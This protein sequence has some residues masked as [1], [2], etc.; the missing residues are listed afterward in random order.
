MSDIKSLVATIDALAEKATKGEE[1]TFGARYLCAHTIKDSL[2]IA[3]YI[4]LAQRLDDQYDGEQWNANMAFIAALRNAWPDLKAAL[5]PLAEPVGMPE[6]PRQDADGLWSM[7]EGRAPH[8]LTAWHSYAVALRAELAREK[9]DHQFSVDTVR[10]I[11]E[12]MWEKRVAAATARAEDTQRM[13]EAEHDAHMECHR[14]AEASER[15]A[16][17]YR[18]L[19]KLFADSTFSIFTDGPE[20]TIYLNG[21]VLARGKGLTPTLDAALDAAGRSG[22]E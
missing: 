11:M 20:V 12:P 4:N 8:P 15:D 18:G 21:N 1:W 17:R 10:N 7:P 5:A 3:E 9:A 13:L 14:K 22:D 2:A 19:L 16:K 6:E